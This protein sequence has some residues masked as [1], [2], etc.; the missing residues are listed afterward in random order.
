MDA[1]RDPTG[2]LAQTEFFASTQAQRESAVE[3]WYR[4]GGEYFITWCDQNYR[5]HDGIPLSWEEP[6]FRELMLMIGN[7]WITRLVVIKAAQMGFSESLFALCAF[8]L[9]EIRIGVGFCVDIKNKL[10]DV[11]GPRV[12]PAFDQCPPIIALREQTRT[13]RGRPDID[14]KQRVLTVGGVPLTFAYAGKQ[15]K[16]GD[17]ASG[18][19]Q[20]SSSLSSFTA[21][22]IVADEIDGYPL[23]RDVLAILKERQSA[24]NLPTK[25]MRC[26]TTPGGEGGVVDLQIKSSEYFFDWWVKCPHCG[27]EQFLHPFGNLC[28]KTLVEED[29]VSEEQY[30]TV[31]GEPHDWFS[32][33]AKD[34][35]RE[36]RINAAYLGCR[37]CAQEIT[38][39]EIDAGCYANILDCD[40]GGGSMTKGITAMDYCRLL[41][42][43]KPSRNKTVTISMN[44]LSSRKFDIAESL[45]DVF[46]TLNKADIWQQRF[47]V[48]VSVGGGK[49]NRSKLL[50]CVGRKP[51]ERPPD[52]IVMG[53]DQGQGANIALID[54]YWLGD[55]GDDRQ[56]WIDAIKLT[57]W[58]DYVTGG[59][60]AL[61]EIARRHHVQI[62]G[63]D[64]DPETQ[65]CA[66]WARAYPAARQLTPG[67]LQVI[68]LDQ[69][70]IDQGEPYRRTERDV[71]GVKVPSFSI[72]RT[73]GYDVVR[74]RILLGRHCLPSGMVI[75][76][77]DEYNFLHHF[78]TIERQT[79]Q[80]RWSHAKPDHYMA[81]AAFSEMAVEV[82]QCLPKPKPMVFSTMK[83]D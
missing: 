38:T 34:A 53:A 72:D 58:A 61:A 13:Q 26:G 39:A 80:K 35:S 5:T 37:S 74:D 3:R 54:H 71:Q 23:N 76:E 36:A 70:V 68:P 17:K 14:T 31:A 46:A 77:K 49:I 41:F 82:F 44:R 45:T 33:A 29:G 1:A 19:R 57:V 11:I 9:A 59:F 16:G 7:P 69:V 18:G 8:L 25:V 48:I 60:D 28:I 10:E 78:Q 62:I 24:S 15:S 51:P 20:V 30:L 63:V 21:P 42:E 64:M 12:Q 83:M 40:P 4:V 67:K 66:E 32:H 6:Y 55:D 52:L 56:R 79:S 43:Q 50:G 65:K 75:D 73:H 22:A 47:G 81:A 2:A 27:Y